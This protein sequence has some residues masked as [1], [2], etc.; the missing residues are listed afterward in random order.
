MLL[1]DYEG[2]VK[3]GLTISPI[4]MFPCD[5]R[6]SFCIFFF[7]FFFYFLKYEFCF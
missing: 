3:V 2:G 1:G 6:V 5:L 7:I 4:L